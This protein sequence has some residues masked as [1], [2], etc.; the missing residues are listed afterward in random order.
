M[1]GAVLPGGSDGTPNLV[2]VPGGLG[3]GVML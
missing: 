1:S 3:Y 2:A